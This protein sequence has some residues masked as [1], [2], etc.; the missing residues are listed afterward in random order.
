MK[1][2][3]FA[4]P[5]RGGRAD[6]DLYRQMIDP[7]W[8]VLLIVEIIPYLRRKT[9]KKI[10]F[11]YVVLVLPVLAAAQGLVIHDASN[12]ISEE[13]VP[14]CAVF[15][16]VYYNSQ[17]WFDLSQLIERYTYAQAAQEMGQQVE[18]FKAL[19]EDAEKRGDKADAES[20]RQ[21]MENLK[22]AI[23]QML[24]EGKGLSGAALRD[25]LL[26]H[27]IGGRLFYAA[28]LAFPDCAKVQGKPY[29]DDDFNCWGLMDA[30]GTI[31]IP[32]RYQDIFTSYNRE[33]GDRLPLVFGIH[34]TD[35]WKD[36]WKVDVYRPDGTLA[37]KQQFA[38]V[39]IFD[40]HSIGVRFLDGGWGLMNENCRILTTRKYKKL[41]TNQNNLIDSSEGWFIYGQRDGVNYILSPEDGSE[42]GTFKLTDNTHEV[43]YYPGKAP[44]GL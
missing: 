30:K 2:V 14:K 23:A 36:Q 17:E 12:L 29:K 41:D 20:Y 22:E 7:P 16:E 4:G 43:N 33:S 42:I 15:T 19:A 28:D 25:S 11:L 6:A 13:G 40:N 21:T 3:Y 8:P 39:Y 10:V 9:M 38:G 35:R 1:K 32:C 34:E 31:V 18:A 24:A 44:K 26:S 27:A 5:I 37:T